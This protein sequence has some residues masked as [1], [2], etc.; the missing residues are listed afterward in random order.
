MVAPK[1]NNIPG[2][3]SLIPTRI[4]VIAETQH[5]ASKINV[6]VRLWG[7]DRASSIITSLFKHYIIR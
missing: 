2:G 4:A 5:T 1:A 6:T 3:L 7:V